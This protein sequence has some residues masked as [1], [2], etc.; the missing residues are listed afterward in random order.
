ME[1]QNRSKMRTE[2]SIAWSGNK[3]HSNDRNRSI[4][5]ANIDKSLELFLNYSVFRKRSDLRMPITWLYHKDFTILA[6]N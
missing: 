4:R 3:S 5:L 1:T 6:M 2:S